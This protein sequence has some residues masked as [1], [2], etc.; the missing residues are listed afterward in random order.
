[1]L[2]M[3]IIDYA[4]TVNSATK[5]LLQDPLMGW[6]DTEVLLSQVTIVFQLAASQS[7]S[8]FGVEYACSDCLDLKARQN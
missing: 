6:D 2:K 7:L 5:A 4:S 8:F 3:Q 1:M